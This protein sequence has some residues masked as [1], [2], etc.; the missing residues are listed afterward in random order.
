MKDGALL[1]IHDIYARNPEGA[2]GLGNLAIRCCLAGAVSQE[3][4]LGRLAGHGFKIQLWEDH[5]RALKEYAARLI[6]TYGSLE[7]FWSC[8][9]DLAHQRQA[10]EIQNAVIQS[11]PGYFL[12][13]AQKA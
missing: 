4:W 11:N 5:T 2:A 13:L 3:A 12:L 8:S 10:G 7:A 1:L 6:F 9:G